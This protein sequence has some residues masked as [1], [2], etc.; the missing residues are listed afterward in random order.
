MYRLSLDRA[1][2]LLSPAIF[3]LWRLLRI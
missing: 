3:V 1:I 2:F